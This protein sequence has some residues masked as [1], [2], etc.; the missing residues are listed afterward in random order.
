MTCFVAT[1]R[2]KPGREAEFERLQRE[3]SQLTH[4]QEPDAY[5]YDIIRHRDQR[6]TYIVYARFKDEAA[7]QLHMK[8]P[9]HD[10]LVPPILD[11]VEGSMDLQF[12]EWIA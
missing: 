10:R 4:Q 1:L 12:Y 8:A 11:C 5:V 9:F 3:L 6:N 7:F 2:I